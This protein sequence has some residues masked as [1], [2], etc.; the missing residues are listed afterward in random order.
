MAIGFFEV[1]KMFWNLVEV[2]VMQHHECTKCHQTVHFK[3][4]SFMLCEIHLN[5]KR[6]R[7]RQTLYPTVCWSLSSHCKAQGELLTNLQGNH[8]HH[9]TAIFLFADPLG[10]SERNDGKILI[11][12][13][14]LSWLLTKTKLLLPLDSCY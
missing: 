6:G 1:M 8:A 7:Q 12:R 11:F 5:L 9:C 2:V 3:T 10:I 14:H 13:M 4:V